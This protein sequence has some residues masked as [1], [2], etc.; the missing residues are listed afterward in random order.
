[1][2]SLNTQKSYEACFNDLKPET[3]GLKS[4]LNRNNLSM[5]AQYFKT[6]V[7]QAMPDY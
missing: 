5:L 6:P 2:A 4:N 7:K 1:M 3:K